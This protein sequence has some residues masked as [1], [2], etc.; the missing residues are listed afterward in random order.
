MDSE[1]LDIRSSLKA[2]AAT[3]RRDLSAHLDPEQLL[4]YRAGNLSPEAIEPLRDHLALCPE[5]AELLLDLDEFAS[6]P[7]PSAAP[8]SDRDLESAWK[9]VR[10]ELVEEGRLEEKALKPL[11]EPASARGS[12]SFARRPERRQ[13]RWLV[14]GLA[15]S[16]V[17]CLGLATWVV[18]LIA[19][20]T[21]LADRSRQ[22]HPLEIA[23]LPTLELKEPTRGSEEV[24]TVASAN[25][26]GF[27]LHF[28]LPGDIPSGGYSVE[29]V[30]KGESGKPIWSE[31]HSDQ[32]G[33]SV[34]VSIQAEA[35]RAGSYT[36]RLTSLVDAS[37]EVEFQFVVGGSG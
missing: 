12:S 11:G 5:C 29:L 34:S 1:R 13:S 35:L 4:A 22:A 20:S 23:T 18:T 9:D 14:Y 19:E 7:P 24:P 32:A 30:R 36:L 21:S 33:D 16:L 8:V 37:K 31:S 3:A 27:V 10:R 17:A 26:H 28:W 15:A 25:P 6:E 2:L